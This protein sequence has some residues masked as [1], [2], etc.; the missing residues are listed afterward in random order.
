MRATCRLI[1]LIALLT[2]LAVDAS[3]AQKKRWVITDYGAI[4]DGKTTNTL[5]IQSVIDRCA[6][7]GG[8]VVVVPQGTFLSGALFFRQGC[9]L[10]VEKGAVLKGSPNVKDYPVV[11]TRWEGIERDWIS[12]F[13]NF[14]DM[15][16]VTLSGEGTIAG[17]GDQ[18]GRY[19]RRRRMPPGQ[20]PSRGVASGARQPG[21]MPGQMPGQTPGQQPGQM[22]DQMSGQMPDQM[23]GQTP[24]QQP[25]QMPSRGAARGAQQPGRSFARGASIPGLGQMGYRRPRMIC[26]TNCKRVRVADLHMRNQQ[27][28]CLHVLY[29]EDVVIEGLDIHA[30]HYIPSSDGIDIDSCRRVQIRTCYIDV[31]DDCISIKSGKDEDG[32]RVNRPSEDILVEQVLFGYGHGGVAMGSEVSGGIRDVTVRNC[33]AFAGQ[34]APVR[35]KS[36]P[37]RGGTIENVT[38]K[39]IQI[40]DALAA[41]DFNMEWRMVGPIAPEAKT[42]TKIRNVKLINVSGKVASGGMIQGMEKS[43]IDGLI[44]KDCVIEAQKPL[45]IENARDLDLSGLKITTPT[46]ASIVKRNVQ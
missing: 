26:F 37:S 25:G 27:S 5:A 29:S 17:S 4:G 28:W 1:V 2:T 38:Y 7:G 39:N 18:P 6:W 3:A 16:D 10:L 24:D 19:R 12:A 20:A 15:T 8:G 9:D 36:Q 30:E 40:I 22:P 46:G 23:L 21:Q 34:W 33:V 42:L 35:F 13:L 45:T 31:N 32:R 11:F 43:P 41:F 44:F 14:D